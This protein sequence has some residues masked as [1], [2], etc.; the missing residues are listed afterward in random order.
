MKRSADSRA[1]AGGS[2]NAYSRI[3]EAI[4]TQRFRPGLE[5]VD[6]ERREI[7]SVAA[8]LGIPL[9]KNLGDVIYSFRYRQR[10]PERIRLAA[11]PGKSWIIRPAGR[12]K[13]S[14]VA[15]A[16]AQIKPNPSLASTRIPDATPGII[17]M[18]RLGDEQALLARLRYNRLIDIFTG[19][20]CY[21][22]Q[23]HLRTTVDGLGQVETDELYVGLDRRGVH[24]VFPVQ[25][26]RG[27]D[28]ISIVQIEQDLAMCSAKFPDLVCIPIAACAIKDGLIALFAFERSP[29]DGDSGTVAV[30]VEKHYLLLPPEEISPD[31]LRSYSKN[32][33]DGTR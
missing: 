33:L 27:D 13:Y 8:R 3:L 6:F 4:F 12:S 18:Y 22:L 23:S 11:P 7:E 24:Y 29:T 26:K 14:F 21:A 30:T 20:T 10:L 19:I 2:G 31:E 5:R 28:N 25:A 17:E 15:A 9:P 1:G 16:A 32:R